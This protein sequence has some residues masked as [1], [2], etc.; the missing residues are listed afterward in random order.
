MFRLVR[1]RCVESGSFVNELLMRFKEACCRSLNI[2]EVSTFD[3]S[4]EANAKFPSPYPRS[5]WFKNVV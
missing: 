3:F 1:G 4:D 5:F 2:V